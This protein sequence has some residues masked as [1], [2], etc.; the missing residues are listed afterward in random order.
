MFVVFVTWDRVLDLTWALLESI[1][2]IAAH[3]IPIILQ[4]EG[5]EHASVAAY[6]EALRVLTEAV[7]L[8]PPA[9]RWRAV[10]VR[11]LPQLHRILW[12]GKRGI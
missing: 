6:A 12:G 7:A 5:L 8:G 1:P 9:A 4:P 10:P 2:E 3:Q 11:V